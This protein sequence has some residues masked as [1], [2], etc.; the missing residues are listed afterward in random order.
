MVETGEGF[1]SVALAASDAHSADGT[2]ED[3]RSLFGRSCFSLAMI[4]GLAL[5]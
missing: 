2:M 3:R 4:S 5:R 1:G